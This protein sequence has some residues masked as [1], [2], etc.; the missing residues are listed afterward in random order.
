MKNPSEPVVASKERQLQSHSS[1]TYHK[2]TAE[3]G[4]WKKK[5]RTRK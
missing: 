1:V 4:T 2:R 5:E 3:V